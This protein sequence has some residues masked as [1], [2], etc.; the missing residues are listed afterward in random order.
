MTTLITPD[1]LPTLVEALDNATHTALDTETYGFG[2]RS[3]GTVRV[4]SFACQTGRHSV[5]TYVVD[6]ND[7]PELGNLAEALAGRAFDGWNANFDAQVLDALF[8]CDMQ[9]AWWDGMIVDALLYQ[10]MS[11]FRF[12]HS[13]AWA[14]DRYLGTTLTGKGTTQTS[15]TESDPLTA[16]QIRYAGEDASNTLGVCNQLRKEVHNLGLDY[17]TELELNSRPF[18]DHM[19]RHGIPINWPTWQKV[20]DEKALRVAEKTNVELAELMGIGQGTLFGAV[21]PVI[22]PAST[23]ALKRTLNELAEE[24]VREYTEATYGSPRLLESSDKLDGLALQ[25]IDHPLAAVILSFKKDKKVLSTYGTNLKKHVWDDARMRPSYMQVVGTG[26]G[27][28][29]SRNPNAQNL[30][31]LLK[32]HFQAPPGR[33]FV[34]ADLSQ[35]ELRFLA[36]LSGDEVMRTAFREERDI[37]EATAEAMLNLDMA[38]LKESDPAHYKT[39]RAVGK[40]LNFSIIYGFGAT[41][42][43]KTLTLNQR[44]EAQEA[45]RSKEE[46]RAIEVTKDEAAALIDAYRAG[47]PQVAAWL[48]ERARIVKRAVASLPTIDWKS[49]TEL[50][51]TLREIGNAPMRFQKKHGH[52]PDGRQLAE[53]V[54]QYSRGYELVQKAKRFEWAMRFEA[55]VV[56]EDRDTPYTMYSFTD[57]GRRRHFN[58][59]MDRIYET[60]VQLMLRSD[61]DATVNIIIEKAAEHGAVLHPGMTNDEIYDVFKGRGPKVPDKKKV[62]EACGRG[63]KSWVLEELMGRALAQRVGGY[64]NAVKNHPIQGGVGDA[65]LLSY[66]LIWERLLD[67]G[68]SNVYPAQTVHDSVT[69]ECDAADAEQVQKILKSALEDGLRHFCPNVPAQADASILTT[70]DEADTWDGSASREFDSL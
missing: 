42:L 63:R 32:P 17:A 13:L 50:Y 70:L 48:D 57:S 54:D 7:F 49:S 23:P 45:G 31:P 52:R 18:L 35:A 34:Y 41:A 28:L 53:F 55:A 65:V 9:L 8:G 43:G 67:S 37:H 27:R 5:E 10:G 15:F 14:A 59:P 66:A 4:M 58:V 40:Q 44:A 36:E 39:A 51:E 38:A 69:L 24:A 12:Y 6:V 56:L 22:N 29:S 21:E 2:R 3:K 47:Y 1:S 19:E 68:L 60:C 20:L 64:T 62:I 26:T 61:K 33:V 46:V 11:G 30:T 25:Q 16:E